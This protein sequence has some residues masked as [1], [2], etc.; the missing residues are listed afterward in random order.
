MAEKPSDRAKAGNSN[1]KPRPEIYAIVNGKKFTRPGLETVF[2]EAKSGTEGSAESSGAVASFCSC[3][4][5]CTCIPV[6][7]CEAYTTGCSCESNSTCSCDSHSSGG[8]VTT[9][10]QCAP[11]H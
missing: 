6:C 2:A 11:V 7:R 8:G 5:V 10:C 1:E 3:N 4:K 9:G